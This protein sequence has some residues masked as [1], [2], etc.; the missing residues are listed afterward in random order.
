VTRSI[1]PVWQPRYAEH[2]IATFPVT[3][4]KTPATKGYLRTGLR[5]S[6]QLAAKFH[7]DALGFACGPRNRITVLDVD[8]TDERVLADALNRHGSTPLVVRT[9][10]GKWHAYYRHNGER[11]QIRPVRDVPIDILGGGYAVA[12][13]SRVTRGEYEF[14][15][16]TLDDLACLPF[17][18]V[19]QAEAPAILPVISVPPA[20]AEMEDGDGR[21]KEL[22]MQCMRSARHY[23]SLDQMLE[24]ARSVNQ[25]FKEPL[26]D[27]EV[28]TV[29]KS[30]W[31]YES[32]GLNFY[33]RPRVVIDHDTVDALALAHP[34]AMVLLLVLER[35]HGGNASFV[36]ANAMTIKMGWTL[37]RWRAA[38]DYL[39]KHGYI[40]LIRQGGRGPHDPPIYGWPQHPEVTALLNLA[41]GVR[42]H[43]PI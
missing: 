12:P 41:K 30:A 8:T 24:V 3:D 5:G 2:R 20:L 28:A 22:W 42:N 31:K 43:S 15:Q 37:A 38:R 29:A 33:S 7:V 27:S 26:M 36:L 11:R 4:N 14:I 17:M 40:Q 16:G 6:G 23:R 39:V 19:V 21:N 9:A 18:R 25:T 32:N 13:P 10:S 35:Y 1:F 34:D